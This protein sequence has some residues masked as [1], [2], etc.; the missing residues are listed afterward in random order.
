MTKKGMEELL[1][2]L[3]FHLEQN[4]ETCATTREEAGTPASGSTGANSVNVKR[5]E[6][7]SPLVPHIVKGD[8]PCD[9]RYVLQWIQTALLLKIC[10]GS[11]TMLHHELALKQCKPLLDG[12]QLKEYSS[13]L[14]FSTH[15]GS[16][17]L[18]ITHF[19]K[20]DVPTSPALSKEFIATFMWARRQV[21]LL[22][23]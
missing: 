1:Q 12:A 20:L 16:V 4:T 6:A 10:D 5:V 14:L 21:S 22:S 23:C 15:S 2:T 18:R 9:I 19:M 17:P 3:T 11:K 13:R 8:S 7:T